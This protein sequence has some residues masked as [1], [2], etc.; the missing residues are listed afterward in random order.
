M[1]FF[2]K[3]E[4]AEKLLKPL[5][6]FFVPAKYKNKLKASF[7]DFYNGINLLRR[8]KVAMIKAGLLSFF[9]WWIVSLQYYLLA[10]AMNITINY[11]VLFMIFPTILLVEIIPISISGLGTRDATL[12]LF[13]SFIG[14][15]ASAAV[16][17]SLSILIF[18]YIYS[19]VGLFIWIRN[20]IKL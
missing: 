13:F 10:K 14:L 18:S 8:N 6:N 4:R 17:L 11:F 20:P 7:G 19:L 3:K 16:A 15:S 1:A 12:I 9:A 5:Y 2:L